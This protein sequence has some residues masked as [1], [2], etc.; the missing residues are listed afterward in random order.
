[1][2]FRAELM[3]NGKTATGFVV[4][5]EVVEGL[6]A[7]KRPPVVV[8]LN[9]QSFRTSIAPMGGRYL[10]GVSAVNREATGATAGSSYDVGV[11]VDTEPRVVEVP[12]DLAKALATSPAAQTLYDTLSYSQQRRAV[13]PIEDA[14]TPE[15]RARRIEKV[16][17]QLTAGTRP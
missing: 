12:D 7:G 5:A 17:A 14:K 2:Q 4:P 8:T 13:E 3:L 16:V 9:G 6:A 11:E 10:L 15:T 1:M